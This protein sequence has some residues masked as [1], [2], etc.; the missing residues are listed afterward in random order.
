MTIRG[1]RT[2]CERCQAPEVFP[3]NLPILSL[4]IDLLPAY[5]VPGAMGAATLQE[6]FDR[7]S[8]PGLMDL[9][10]IPPAERAATWSSLRELESELRCIRAARSEKTP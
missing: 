7:A 4:F 10:S 6:G 1:E 5:R 2:W 8:V 3:E 9:H